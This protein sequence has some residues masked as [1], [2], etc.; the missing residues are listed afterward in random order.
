[1]RL[2]FLDFLFPTR[3]DERI[4][5]NVSVDEF[6]SLLSPTLSPYTDPGTTALLPFRHAQVRSVIHEA[7]YHGTDESFALL[8]ETLS[9]YLNDSDEPLTHAVLI[10]VPI[11]TRRFRERGYNQAEELARRA[12]TKLSIAIEAHAL[13]R[14]RETDSQISLAREA[15]RTNMRGAFCAAG[16][17]SPHALHI[18]IDD[19]TTTGATMQAAIDA[20][21]AAGA[22]HI[23]PI[24]LAH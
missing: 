3:G 16:P 11:G 4:A 14:T 17:R 10:P 2:S 19:V 21:R 12:G 20:L 8:A 13:R 24:A 1:M 7:K 18:V 15:R 6:L 22:V 23:L 9:T 5:K